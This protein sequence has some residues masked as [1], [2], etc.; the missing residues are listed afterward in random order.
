MIYGVLP[1]RPAERPRPQ[2]IKYSFITIG[3][4]S[5]S[6]VQTKRNDSSLL[7]HKLYLI[8]SGGGPRF[9]QN[10]WTALIIGAGAQFFCLVWILLFGSNSFFSLN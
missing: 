7:L 4:K 9:E 6:L 8:S 2:G 1:A 10:E 5:I 3:N